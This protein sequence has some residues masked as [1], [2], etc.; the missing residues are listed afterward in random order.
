MEIQGLRRELRLWDV[1]GFNVAAILGLRWIP[2][3]AASG[4]VS[5]TIWLLAVLFFFLPQGFAVSELS[6]RFPDEGGIYVWTKKAFGD[7]HDFICG[8]CYWGNN[9]SYYPSLLI[10]AAG[11]SAMIGGEKAKWLAD[12][13]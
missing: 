5:L 11:I 6:T 9:L 13:H 8:W 2:L 7:F 12:N 4:Y 10:S 1:V 3:A